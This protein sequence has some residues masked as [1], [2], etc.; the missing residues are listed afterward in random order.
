MKQLHIMSIAFPINVREAMLGKHTDPK[1]CNSRN[2]GMISQTVLYKN[3]NWC[4]MLT[5]TTTT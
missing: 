5:K 4:N 1:L 2:T 3:L